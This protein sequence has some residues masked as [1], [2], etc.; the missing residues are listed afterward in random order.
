MGHG[1]EDSEFV[2]RQISKLNGLLIK[3]IAAGSWSSMVLTADRRVYSFG[4]NKNGMLGHDAQIH[5]FLCIPK[6]VESLPNDVIKVSLGGF[7]A[8][9]LTKKGYVY[10]CG[11]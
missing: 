5:P 6:R 2:P 9:F 3:Q 11:R 1:S 8:L 10:G 7:H 4:L